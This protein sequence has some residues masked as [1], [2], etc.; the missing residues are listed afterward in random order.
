MSDGSNPAVMVEDEGEKGLVQYLEE[1]GGFEVDM[2]ILREYELRRQ[3]VLN[4]VQN[5]W[6]NRDSV[7]MLPTSTWDD[8]KVAILWLVPSNFT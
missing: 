5:G 6:F 8:A 7:R 4:S 1:D 2:K 3:C